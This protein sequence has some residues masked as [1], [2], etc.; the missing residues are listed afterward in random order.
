ML[1]AIERLL[2]QS[3]RDGRTCGDPIGQV[4][5]STTR[6]TTPSRSA[7]S[8]SIVSPVNASSQALAMPTMRGSR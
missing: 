5:G 6:E 8:A 2:G 4:E 3:D 7:S 1:S